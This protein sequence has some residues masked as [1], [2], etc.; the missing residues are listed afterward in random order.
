MLCLPKIKPLKTNS[1]IILVAPLLVTYHFVYVYNLFISI[2]IC[3]TVSVLFNGTHCIFAPFVKRQFIVKHIY[4][5][6]WW[7]YDS[8]TILH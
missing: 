8:G 5:L 6:F 2:L 3:Y 7:L 1:S 4:L